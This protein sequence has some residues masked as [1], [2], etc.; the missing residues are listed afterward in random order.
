MRICHPARVELRSAV[1]PSVSGAEVHIG[2]CGGLP[3]LVVPIRLA[4][5]ERL[6]PCGGEA[7]GAG[8]STV[9]G[10]LLFHRREGRE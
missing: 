1:V 3:F 8:D 10:E 5:T 6:S 4:L 2:D 7:G 9:Q